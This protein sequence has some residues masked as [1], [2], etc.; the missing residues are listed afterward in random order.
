MSGLF[1]ASL[2]AYIPDVTVSRKRGTSALPWPPAVHS[3]YIEGGEKKTQ[4]SK[5]K[6][7]LTNSMET[8][9]GHYKKSKSYILLLFLNL[10]FQSLL[11]PYLLSKKARVIYALI[12]QN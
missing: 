5:E 11:G 3:L 4:T 12:T 7:I 2:A 9:N 10:S 6:S 8:R 1:N